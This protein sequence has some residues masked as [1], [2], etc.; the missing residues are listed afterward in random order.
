[1]VL[2]GIRRARPEV[3]QSEYFRLYYAAGLYFRSR[4]PV[5]GEAILAT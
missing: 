2:A 5:I 1:M 4:D 3:N